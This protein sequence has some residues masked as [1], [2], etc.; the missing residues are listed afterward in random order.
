MERQVPLVSSGTIGHR[1]AYRSSAG[2]QVIE[3]AVRDLLERMG[4]TVLAGEAS[5]WTTLF[6]LLLR[7]ALLSPVPGALPTPYLSG[8]LDLGTP[9]FFVRRR[10]L[11]LEILDQV[12]AGQ[13]PSILHQRFHSHH[14]E[15]LWGV[16]WNRYDLEQLSALAQAAGP[17]AL[18]RV[19]EIMARGGT[20][21]LRGLPDLCVLP[22]PAIRVP[23]SL[24][25]TLPSQLLLVEIKGPGDQLS[26]AQRTWNDRLLTAGV[27]VE[28]WRIQARENSP[29]DGS[30]AVG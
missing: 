5:P 9:D 22:G 1:P 28:T 19:L 15:R 16:H 29:D 8:P 6:G 3:L 25:S 20:E 11:I 10:A 18:A 24:P 2:P 4:R 23:D 30:R 14:G 17:S 12:R 27:A 13:A 21:A 7:P 26:D